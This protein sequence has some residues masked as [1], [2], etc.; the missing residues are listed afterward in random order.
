LPV[1]T[2]TNFFGNSNF[3]GQTYEKDFFGKIS[4]R[5]IKAC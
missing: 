3:A 2:T 4:I 5:L 1:T